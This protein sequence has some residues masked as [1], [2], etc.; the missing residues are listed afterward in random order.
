MVE[1]LPARQRRRRLAG[2][3]GAARGDAVDALEVAVP[4]LQLPR[5]RAARASRRRRERALAVH[6]QH[7]RRSGAAAAEVVQLGRVRLEGRL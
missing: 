2:E 3:V 5:L 6:L 7:E 1:Q 4:L